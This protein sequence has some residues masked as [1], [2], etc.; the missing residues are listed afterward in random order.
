VRTVGFLRTAT[1]GA[2]PTAC[3]GLTRGAEPGVQPAL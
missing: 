1:D 3:P 2:A